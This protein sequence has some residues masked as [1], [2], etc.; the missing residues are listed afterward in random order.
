MRGE[1][2]WAALLW[3]YHVAAIDEHPRLLLGPLFVLLLVH[4]KGILVRD[5][6]HFALAFWYVYV[7][8]VVE[9]PGRDESWGRGEGEGDTAVVL[10][11]R[12]EYMSEWSGEG[13]LT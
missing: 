2:A 13:K 4:D 10:Q 9:C 7:G 1:H 12:V 3:T 6:A 8:A 5:P 11:E